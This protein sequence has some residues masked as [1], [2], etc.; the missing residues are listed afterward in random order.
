MSAA[1]DLTAVLALSDEAPDLEEIL[2]Q[3]GA[4]F[5][6]HGLEHEWLLVI[7]G[8]PEPK[9]ARIKSRV[10][11]GEPVRFL[12]FNQA[13]GEERS[14]ASAYREARGRYVVTLPSYLQL[15]PGD[16]HPVL[17]ALES[18]YDVIVGW[19]V[20]RVDPWMNRLQSWTYNRAMSA[21]T[22]VPLHDLNCGLV[23]LRRPVIDE[24]LVEGNVSRFLPILAHRQG[25]RV[26]EVR[27]RHLR[28]RGRQGFFGVGVYVRRLLDVV[29]LLFIT[30]FTRKPLRFFGA[31]GGI[32]V[33]AGLLL[34]AYLFL[35]IQL[36]WSHVGSLRNSTAFVFGVALIMIGVQTF[37]IGLVAEIIIFTTARNVR[38]YVIEREL[39]L[40]RG[41][42][43]PAPPGAAERRAPE[44]EAGR[45]P[46]S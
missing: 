44:P 39:L 4:E 8:L 26:G 27:V 35:D 5:R 16:I 24:V 21:F 20:P 36:G 42:P 17:S 3:Y 41:A 6:E 37:S 31:A 43:K 32:A 28:E 40:G 45:E 38:E 13:F 18:D 9:V 29:A 33:L 34:C 19:R 7:D 10:P 1:P 15:D 11:A 22:G 14:L 25:F 30:R 12:H 46:A 23:G 2:R